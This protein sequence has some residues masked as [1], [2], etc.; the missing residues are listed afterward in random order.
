MAVPCTS[1][2]YELH[3]YHDKEEASKEV[4]IHDVRPCRKEIL[5]IYKY[6]RFIG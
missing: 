2:S 4:G 3:K 6:I 1:V 5:L